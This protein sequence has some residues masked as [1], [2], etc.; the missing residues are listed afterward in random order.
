MCFPHF[1]RPRCHMVASGHYYW[2]I[3]LYFEKS[4]HGFWMRSLRLIFL[5]HP[6][7]FPS[8][9][10]FLPY[11]HCC[12]W[13][14]VLADLRTK[15]RPLPMMPSRYIIY[16]T[17]LVTTYSIHTVVFNKSSMLTYLT[18]VLVATTTV[19][20]YCRSSHRLRAQTSFFFL[21]LLHCRLS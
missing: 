17:C 11:N 18:L 13:G 12:D 20:E 15:G 9:L 21:F 3:P 1:S 5:T 16:I 8:S 2:I 14:M 7:F 4:A 19:F 10:S 6:P